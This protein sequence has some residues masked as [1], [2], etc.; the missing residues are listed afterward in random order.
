MRSGWRTVAQ[1]EAPPVIGAHSLARHQVLARYIARY[2]QVRTQVPRQDGT[3]ITLVDGFAGGRR[4][5]R[6]DTGAV[7]PGSPLLMMRALKYAEAEIAAR[8]KKPLRL[9]A[10][11]V[12]VEKSPQNAAYLRMVLP[13]GGHAGREDVAVVEGSFEEKVHAIVADIQARG[14]ADRSIFLLDQYGYK[15]VFL[16]TT[17]DLFAKLPQAEVVLTFATDWLID[18]LADTP[19]HAKALSGL[20]LSPAQLLEHE[21]GPL[22]RRAIELELLGHLQAETGAKFYAPFFVVS[23]DAHRS[24]W[25]VHLSG[26]PKARDVMTQ[27]HWEIHNCFAHYAGAGLD[28]SGSTWSATTPAWTP[29]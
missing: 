10:R 24:Y 13:E 27:L 5:R 15:D 8:K 17:R 3:K 11:F 25:L 9:D 16:G 21:D 19:L 23:P 28:M 26:H 2:M 20:G 7:H 1:G 12:F 22:W 14:R 29:V 6:E 4:Y 18:P